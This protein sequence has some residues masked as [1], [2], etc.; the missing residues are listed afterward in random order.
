MRRFNPPPNW[1]PPP[2]DFAYSEHWRP[3]PSWGPAP[4]GWNLWLNDDPQELTQQLDT[5]PSPSRRRAQAGDIRNAVIRAAQSDGARAAAGAVARVVRD[6][7][8]T[9]V[10]KGA[11]V[12]VAVATVRKG[13]QRYGLP[14]P[15][16]VQ[17]A[18]KDAAAPL[19]SRSSPPPRSLVEPQLVRGRPFDMKLS[20]SS[21]GRLEH[22]PDVSRLWV[23]VSMPGIKR[24]TFVVDSDQGSI[25]PRT[26]FLVGDIPKRWTRV[27]IDGQELPLEVCR[28]A[29]ETVTCCWLVEPYLADAQESGAS[30][31]AADQFDPDVAAAVRDR[32][33]RQFGVGA[34]SRSASDPD[35]GRSLGARLDDQHRDMTGI[36]SNIR[37]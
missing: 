28:T 5:F 22:H 13:A 32:H 23:E 18:I 31:E 15:D 35:L 8:T 24:Y 9:A 6:E 20:W 4:V 12:A 11:A 7:R 27:V 33:L 10:L 16:A 14:I 34:P 36:I 25:V 26:A 37:A 1:P 17:D 2:A 30:A 29:E 3:D 21:T 19:L